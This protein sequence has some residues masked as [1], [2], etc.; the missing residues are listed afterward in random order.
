MKKWLKRLLLAVCLLMLP[1][2]LTGV[3]TYSDTHLEVDYCKTLI[4]YGDGFAGIE[5]NGVLSHIFCTDADGKLTGNIQV[6]NID[7]G[8]QSVKS[9]DQLIEDENGTLYVACTLHEPG[10]N[11]TK[12]IYQADFQ[13]E[14]L[15]LVWEISEEE[16]E[17]SF[18]SEQLFSVID[19]E[20]YFT[21]YQASFDQL[22]TYAKKPGEPTRQVSATERL[23]CE[24]ERYVYTEMGLLALYRNQGIFL[25]NEK[26]YPSTDSGAILLNG[27]GYED[28]TLSFLDFYQRSIIQVNLHTGAVS[29]QPIPQELNLSAL[30]NVHPRSDGTFCA[31][32]EDG[33]A[34]SGIYW[35]GSS[36]QTFRYLQGD[37][38]EHIAGLCFLTAL[39]VELVILGFFWL[40]W[41]RKRNGRQKGERY[42]L[43]VRTRISLSSIAIAM[44][45]AAIITIISSMFMQQYS[46]QRQQL[47]SANAVQS[48]L[49][50]LE[51]KGSVEIYEGGIYGLPQELTSSLNSWISTQTASG[52]DYGY[53]LFLRQNGQ[54]YCVYSSDLTA[55]V[56]VEYAINGQA[57]S[58]C[59]QAVETGVSQSFEDQRS[60]GI[61]RYV[62]SAAD[63]SLKG[64]EN[65]EL[66][67]ASVTD[68]Y[69]QQVM[70]LESV[71]VLL[72]VAAGTWL[73]LL[74]V[75][76][77]LIWLFMKRL[78]RL[79][80]ELSR[81]AA[82]GEWKITDFAGQD[83]VA[84]TAQTM[85]AMTGSIQ[86][87]LRDIRTCNGQYELLIPKDMIRL[88]GADS[89]AQVHAGQ[90]VKQNVMLLT[91]SFHSNL[92]Q[93]VN[94]LMEEGM[95][96]VRRQQGLLVRFD[97]KMLRCCFEK[98][99][100]A[101]AALQQLLDHPVLKHCS[102]LFLTPAVLEAGVIGDQSVKR[103]L[104]LSKEG[105]RLRSLE[106]RWTGPGYRGFFLTQKEGQ[107]DGRLSGYSYRMAGWVEETS[108]YQLISEEE[109]PT[110]L[111]TRMSFEE[112]LCSFRNGD[113]Q[114]AYEIF[115]TICRQDS[116]DLL[117]AYYRMESY[118]GLGGS[119]NEKEG[120]TTAAPMDDHHGD[121]VGRSGS[122]LVGTGP[123]G[124]SG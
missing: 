123:D 63:F 103:V 104:T 8:R 64:G 35:D 97:H 41:V 92:A 93:P 91:I 54:W 39:L 119:V 56:P 82:S 43:S 16:V 88:M 30:Q 90:M 100:Q 84:E 28:G 25:Q 12:A 102:T 11:E 116:Q 38:R 5:E 108:F 112:G 69:S 50:V 75:E 86:V 118:K 89:F 52:L 111:T 77:L 9:F 45:G 17:G 48:L 31:S 15:R 65:C 33:S 59:E 60:A 105:N 13:W 72:R 67:A 115:D 96:A 70:T 98:E 10:G 22:L 121:S 24:P 34:L 80:H 66:V 68:G 73:I 3:V 19:G 27:L 99:E 120:R 40:F 21:L 113:Y 53:E 83:E 87:Y 14:R 76:N 51:R 29:S 110:Q 55:P 122:S 95:E 106:E 124:F 6:L 58:Y 46:R 7:L 42:F 114:T 117:A 109:N 71:L 101:L 85:K 74:L 44:A 107:M 78:R 79:N 4:P 81:S 18:Q 32:M 62:I 2:L 37:L 57:Q 26:I 47:N 20:L 94:R 36:V 1:L 61:L 23:G 49:G